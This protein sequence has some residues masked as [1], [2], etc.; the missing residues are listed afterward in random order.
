MLSI[1]KLRAHHAKNLQLIKTLR[2][3]ISYKDLLI[4]DLKS[5]I[6]N[7]Q[8]TNPHHHDNTRPNPR[9]SPHQR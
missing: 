6:K 2:S 9:R 1:A 4:Y 5:T 7:L 8:A 3:A